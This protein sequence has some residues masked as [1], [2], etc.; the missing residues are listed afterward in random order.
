L[1]LKGRKTDHGE[2]C[3]MMNFAACILHL[4]L[5]GW[6]IKED[7][8]GR[9]RKGEGRAVYRFLLGGPKARDHW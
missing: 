1:D 8:V 6:L 4:M 2:N 5:L 7:E 3:I 9:K